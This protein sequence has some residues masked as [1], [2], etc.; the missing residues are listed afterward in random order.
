MNRCTFGLHPWPHW[1]KAFPVECARPM[2]LD[3]INIPN[4]MKLT[5]VDLTKT[6]EWT[7]YRQE[8]TCPGCGATQRR[9]V[10]S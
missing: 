3:F 4:D 5:G 6:R 9:S 7:E 2:Y 8:R 1:G 10:T